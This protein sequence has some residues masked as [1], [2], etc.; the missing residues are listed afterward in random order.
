[1][2][3]TTPGNR[4]EFRLTFAISIG[5]PQALWAAA[6][7]S[8]LNHPD[9]TL[10]DVLDTIGPREDPSVEDCIT[11]LATP[12]TIAGCA[13]EDFWIDALQPGDDASAAP[14]ITRDALDLRA[15]TV[16]YMR[17]AKRAVARSPQVLGNDA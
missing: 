10:G 13:V 6:A 11:A 16:G 17:R 3:S 9:M 8:L 5:D 12:L 14:Q 15:R 4:A 1:M 2:C 7:A